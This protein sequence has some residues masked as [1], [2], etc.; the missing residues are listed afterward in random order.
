MKRDQLDFG[1]DKIG[2]LFRL[3]FFPTLIGMLFN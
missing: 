2:K 1:N 3:M